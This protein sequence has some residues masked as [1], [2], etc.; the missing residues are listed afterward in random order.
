MNQ[1]KMI[2][3]LSNLNIR[4]GFGGMSFMPLDGEFSWIAARVSGFSFFS[5][6]LS[7]GTEKF[8]RTLLAAATAAVLSKVVF[9]LDILLGKG[10]SSSRPI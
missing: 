2:D 1:F 3:K 5:V 8:F 6:I 9:F 10:V 7:G 4:L